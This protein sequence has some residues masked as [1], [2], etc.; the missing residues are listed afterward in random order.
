VCA[1]LKLENIPRL[2]WVLWEEED[3]LLPLL[4]TQI[5]FSL[6]LS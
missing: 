3:A 1:F 5:G 2:L 6:S 4:P